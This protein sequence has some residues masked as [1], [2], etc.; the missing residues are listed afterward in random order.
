MSKLNIMSVCS[1]DTLLA[2]SKIFSNNVLEIITLTIAEIIK[3]IDLFGNLGIS[4]F[5]CS[6]NGFNPFFIPLFV[7][8]I[9][10]LKITKLIAIIEYLYF[11]FV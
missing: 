2:N 3:V 1:K 4:F 8:Y 6:K 5:S 11:T 9:I 10:V 7:K